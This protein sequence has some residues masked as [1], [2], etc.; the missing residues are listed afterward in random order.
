MFQPPISDNQVKSLSC[1]GGITPV[2]WHQVSVA[3]KFQKLNDS[4][5]GNFFNSSQPSSWE[6]KKKQWQFTPRVLQWNHLESR[7]PAFVGGSYCLMLP[8]QSHVTFFNDQHG[9]FTVF[10]VEVWKAIG[11]FEEL[12]VLHLWLVS[13]MGWCWLKRKNYAC[14][15]INIY[16]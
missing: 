16:I 12:N 2:S 11:S 1:C 8:R 6:E 4:T 14:N 10:S 15:R 7:I 13:G 3:L 5:R 9:N